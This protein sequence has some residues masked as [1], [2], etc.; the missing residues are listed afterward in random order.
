MSYI[1]EQKMVRIIAKYSCVYDGYC[2]DD[3]GTS[4]PGCK[5]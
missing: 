3:V 4:L 5:S 2:F 1:K